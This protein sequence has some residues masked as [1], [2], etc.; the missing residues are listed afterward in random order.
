MSFSLNEL[1]LARRFSSAC[2][3]GR[4]RTKKVIEV[5]RAQLAL[6]LSLPIISKVSQESQTAGPSLLP[7]DRHN[8]RMELE[9]CGFRSLGALEFAH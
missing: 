8:R 7:H 5:P 3:H 6:A 9:D 4:N 1:G 2:M